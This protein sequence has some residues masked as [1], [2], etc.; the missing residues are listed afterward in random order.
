MP[1]TAV[2]QPAHVLAAVGGQTRDLRLEVCTYP[3]GTGA[4]GINK[5]VITISVSP[6]EQLLSLRELLAELAA[7]TSSA[8][9]G[10]QTEV[11]TCAARPKLLSKDDVITRYLGSGVF[12]FQQRT[13]R[14]EVDLGLLSS[15]SAPG[16]IRQ[17]SHRTQLGIGC[18]CQ[19]VLSSL[20]A[21]SHRTLGARCADRVPLGP[22][23]HCRDVGVLEMALLQGLEVANGLPPTLVH[24]HDT[25]NVSFPI[26]VRALNGTVIA[27]EARKMDTIEEI[28]KK[29][30]KKEG[31]RARARRH[32]AMVSS[33]HD[34]AVCSRAS[35]AYPVDQ[36]R[37]I[38]AGK[39]LEDWRTLADYG[40]EQEAT[41]HLVLRLRGGMMHETSCVAKGTEG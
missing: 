11:F 1:E 12:A 25:P 2:A 14:G 21:A 10:A 28:K 22:P 34:V 18:T 24:V 30:E 40:V 9:H 33:A 19:Q 31:E 29:V 39:Q 5:R 3:E 35:A 41:L 15:R 27:V 16:D 6:G 38:F 4:A 8:L 32:N 26:T 13:S 20:A 23:C 36:Q 7:Q 37:L 17:A